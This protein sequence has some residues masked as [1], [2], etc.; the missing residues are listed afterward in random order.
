MHTTTLVLAHPENPGG[1]VW[2]KEVGSRRPINKQTNILDV[3]VHALLVLC[4]HIT[5]VL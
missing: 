4:I 2:A 5:C 3:C 1:C